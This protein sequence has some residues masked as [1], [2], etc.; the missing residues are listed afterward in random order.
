MKKHFQPFLILVVL[1][2][3]SLPALHGYR[4]MLQAIAPAPS[5]HTNAAPGSSP[6]PPPTVLPTPTGG[7]GNVVPQDSGGGSSGPSRLQKARIVIGVLAGACVIGLSTMVYMNRRSNI[8]H[9]RI[10]VLAARSPYV[11][12]LILLIDRKLLLF[13]VI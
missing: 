9:E 5:P 7:G 4:R 10:G 3:A 11:I 13:P 6:P 1:L 12:A 8:Q 2:V